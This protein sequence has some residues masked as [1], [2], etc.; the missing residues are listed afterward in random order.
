MSDSFSNIYI[1]FL[2]FLGAFVL[3]KRSFN[4][5]KSFKQYL[6][7]ELAKYGFQFISS[8][9]YRSKLFDWPFETTDQDIVVNPFFA[10]WGVFNVKVHRHLRKVLIEDK[11]GKKHELIAGIEFDGF[12]D[13]NFKRV[14]WKPELHTISN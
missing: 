5:E 13:R 1:L 6:V 3:I 2:L 10:R 4:S 9:Y 12:F 11:K 14:R 8:T 7:P